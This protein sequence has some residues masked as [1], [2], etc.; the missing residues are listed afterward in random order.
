VRGHEFFEMLDPGVWVFQLC[1]LLAYVIGMTKRMTVY[2]QVTALSS[3]N[4]KPLTTLITL[5]NHD[6]RVP[7]R[8]HQKT[9]VQV[10]TELKISAEPPRLANLHAH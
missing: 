1:C 5:R 2:P 3:V 4:V 8:G 9:S 10:D 6:L 7:A